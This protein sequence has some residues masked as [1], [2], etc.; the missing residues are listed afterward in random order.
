[1]DSAADEAAETATDAADA[2][3]DAAVDA[4]SDIADLMT[5]DGFDL[6]RVIDY[7]D[8]SDLS[9]VVKATSKA[10]LEQARD[11]PEA[12]E[13]VLENLRDRLGIE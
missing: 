5:V 12:L 7:I 3:A 6:D 1:V 11:S 9:N 13:G 8:N 4:G 2:T 10:A